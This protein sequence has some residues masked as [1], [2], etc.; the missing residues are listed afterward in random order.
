M[1][2][3]KKK[4]NAKDLS[5]HT[6][7]G[8]RE[9]SSDTST[10]STSSCMTQIGGTFAASRLGPYQLPSTRFAVVLLLLR[11]VRV[12]VELVLVRGLPGTHTAYRYMYDVVP[13]LP[14][15][16]QVFVLVLQNQAGM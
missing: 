3:Q 4:H 15:L 1:L 14:L 12:P 10:S 5:T 6:I 8:T 2:R 13:V 9:Y 7:T 11:V 16:V